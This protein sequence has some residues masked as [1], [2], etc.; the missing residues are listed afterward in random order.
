MK[1]E[2]KNTYYLAQYIDSY[3]CRTNEG[4]FTKKSFNNYIKEENE[5]RNEEDKF[6]ENIEECKE[7]GE[8]IFT[9]IEVYK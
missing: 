6:G 8:F 2:I 5:Y 1:T 3:G 9:E 4:I 7:L